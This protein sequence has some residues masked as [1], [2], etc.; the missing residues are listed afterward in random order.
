MVE[1]K[2]WDENGILKDEIKAKVEKCHT[3][4]ELFVLWRDAQSEDIKYKDKESK[5]NRIYA[6]KKNSPKICDFIAAES[7]TPDG[8]I[9]KEE[10]DKA[11][12]KVLYIMEEANGNSFNGEINY[13]MPKIS[14]NPSRKY[15][16]ETPIKIDFEDGKEKFWFKGVVE[17]RMKGEKDGRQIYVK[18]NKIQEKITGIENNLKGAAYMNLNKRGGFHKLSGAPVNVWKNY[19]NYISRYLDFII[20]EIKIINPDYIV[21]FKVP[22]IIINKLKEEGFSQIVNYKYHPSARKGDKEF[23]GSVLIITSKVV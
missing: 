13:N 8:F 19:E 1:N 23:W 12:K 22:D 5:S 11:D 9:C 2:Y 16:P 21:G 15:P 17:G 14:E 6:R 4:G 7:F 3:I 18:I 20:R 10:W